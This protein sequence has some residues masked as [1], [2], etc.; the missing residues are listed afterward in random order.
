MSEQ[1]Q[2]NLL[3]RGWRNVREAGTRRLIITALLIVASLCIGYFSWRLPITGSAER[4]LYDA[5]VY[6]QANR[7]AAAPDPRVVM[8][9][10][11][12]DTLISAGKRSPLDRGLLSAALRNLEGMGPRRSVSTC[13]SI[14]RKLRMPS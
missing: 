4:A 2:D 12:D 8:L 6:V 1:K 11:D 14:S 7:Q 3:R 13:C 10:Y 5:R 9:V